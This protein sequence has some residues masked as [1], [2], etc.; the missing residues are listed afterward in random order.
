MNT[1]VNTSVLQPG[2]QDWQDLTQRLMKLPKL[3]PATPQ[4]RER[5][6]AE[7]TAILASAQRQQEQAGA[8][9]D[10]VHAYST[11]IDL[12]QLWAQQAR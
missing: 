3:P 4:D 9:T 11:L 10:L 5:W 6:L 2:Y 8:D 1:S 12:V 7:L